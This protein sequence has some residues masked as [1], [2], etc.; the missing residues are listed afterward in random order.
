M[1]QLIGCT[2]PGCEELPSKRIIAPGDKAE[3]VVKVLN[4]GATTPY[5]Y[6]V[7][8]VRPGAQTAAVD[9]VLRA[10]NVID[11]DVAWENETLLRIGYR[12]ARILNFQNF[13]QDIQIDGS[14]REIAVVE[15]QN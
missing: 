11:L 4:C 1:T 9:Q 8:I 5:D 10:T 12:K 6:R 2:R 3:V 13:W 7:Y 15:R 14:A